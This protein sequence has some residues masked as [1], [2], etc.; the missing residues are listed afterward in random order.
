M[1]KS[2]FLYYYG[3]AKYASIIL[4]EAGS[5]CRVTA[6]LTVFDD[7]TIIVAMIEQTLWFETRDAVKLFLRRWE[8]DSGAPPRGAVQIVHG[9]GEHGLRY[10]ETAAYLC[11]RGYSVWAADMRGHGRT[12]DLSVNPAD[13]GGLL[14]HC[15]DTN[16]FAKILLD[17]EK[18]N[19]GIQKTYPGI[20]LFLLGHS[21]GSFIA[22]GYIETFNKRPLS[23]CALSGTKGPGSAAVALGAP[24]MAVFA[25]LRGVRCRSRF[26]RGL[27]D[28][29]YN[30][31]FQPNRTMYDWLSR[32]KKEVDLFV[33][34]ALCGQLGSVGF[35]RDLAFALKRIHRK[36]A[37][38]RVNRDLPVYLF[39]GSADPVGG[40]GAGP[41]ELV[42]SYRR[43][44]IKDIEFVLYPEARHET[45]HETN[46]EEVMR[47]LCNWLDRHIK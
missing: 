19:A 46:R 34:D 3:T 15:A 2:L 11:D 22:Q 14:G 39:S 38:D 21:W 40:M 37:M 25:A 36:R 47:N 8:S 18:I 45:L 26:S 33:A 35:Y 16:A 7:G 6:G 41:T 44:G 27:A 9:M 29:A 5:S 20:P 31:A 10:A 4:A 13:R 43:I 24:F 12:A 17:V 30:K 28:G 23:G 32:D 1:I 42:D